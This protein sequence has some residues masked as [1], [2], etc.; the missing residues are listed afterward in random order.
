MG[1]GWSNVEEYKEGVE[2]C[3]RSTRRAWNNVK[4]Y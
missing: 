3:R 2:W 1:R 4:E